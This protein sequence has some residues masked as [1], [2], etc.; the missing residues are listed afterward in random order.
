MV[1]IPIHIGILSLLKIRLPPS[2]RQMGGLKNVCPR[3][4][5]G[6]EISEIVLQ[7]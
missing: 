1:S 4:P 6:R 3:V 2:K 5:R 7:E